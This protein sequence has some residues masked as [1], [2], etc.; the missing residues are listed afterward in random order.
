MSITL[1]ELLGKYEFADLSIEHQDNIL[2]LLEKISKVREAYDKPMRVT[3]GYRSMAD[4]ER[5]YKEKGISPNKIPRKSKH[6]YG[7]A[8]DIA[9]PQQAL[10]KWCTANVAKLESIGVWCEDPQYTLG[11][12]HLQIVPPKSGKRFFIP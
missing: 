5:I 12:L 8:V 2:E 10:A 3:S 7:Q 4:H 9:D 11:W 6:L 1:K